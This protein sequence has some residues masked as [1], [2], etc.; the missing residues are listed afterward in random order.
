MK[1][2]WFLFL[3]VLAMGC[4]HSETTP[5]TDIDKL[6]GG[7]TGLILPVSLSVLS[8][9]VIPSEG[10]RLDLRQAKVMKDFPINIHRGLQTIF[11]DVPPGTYTFFDL[12]CG[13]NKTW[14]FTSKKWAP[15]IVV[16]GKI[17][18]GAPMD[19]RINGNGGM[20]TYFFNRN[21]VQ[22]A[23]RDLFAKLKPEAQAGI[24][25]AYSK[26]AIN[27]KM[28]TQTQYQ[29]TVKLP[30]K[31]AVEGE[32]DEANYPDFKACYTNEFTANPL[33]V[34]HISLTSSFSKKVFTKIDLKENNSIYTDQFYNCVQTNL[35]NFVP[36]RSDDLVYDVVL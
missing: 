4:A 10:C 6:D 35:K 13:K 31:H 7:E 20:T 15:M 5:T 30:A 3:M 36:N 17:S 19:L 11:A 2:S 32:P 34:G 1:R 8:A 24:I 26:K 21:G 33:Y 9:D 16:K 28:T 14:D 25:S 12:Y 29:I 18:G 23:Y 22:K 27:A